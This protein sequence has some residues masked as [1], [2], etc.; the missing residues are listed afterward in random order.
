VAHA[1]GFDFDQDFT[2]LRAGKVDLA[3]FEWG[4]GFEGDGGVG[5]HDISFVR[6]SLIP[7]KCSRLIHTLPV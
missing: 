7:N 5:F 3:D 1:G 4:S 6:S 2:R